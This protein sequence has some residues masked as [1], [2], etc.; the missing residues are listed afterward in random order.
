M[1]KAANNVEFVK[2]KTVMQNS[3]DSLSD[4]IKVLSNETKLSIDK[5]NG[6]LG[7]FPTQFT[8][9]INDKI[10]QLSQQNEQHMHKIIQEYATP[11]P[12]AEGQLPSD[13]VM[14]SPTKQEVFAT[15]AQD[16]EDVSLAQVTEGKIDWS[17]DLNDAT[18]DHEIFNAS[19]D[20]HIPKFCPYNDST[21]E[22]ASKWLQDFIEVLV[23]GRV[24]KSR[25]PVAIYSCLEGSALG[26]WHAFR[27]KH[28]SFPWT[29]YRQ[30]FLEA[31]KE[32]N[33]AFT[34]RCR[35]KT[36]TFKDM[37]SYFKNFCKLALL[38]PLDS[39]MDL[40]G[41]T[42]S[43]RSSPLGTVTLSTISSKKILSITLK[44]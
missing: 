22:T 18:N 28:S 26:W 1:F 39:F 43:A 12:L 38:T 36:L 8:Q 17:E 27:K 9:A 3:L 19:K 21:E 41:L 10:T 25:W 30:A 37:D 29:A 35:I 32:W 5:I 2:V 15:D 23:N 20:T 16:S 13:E 34:A 40:S 42:T 31:H 11:Q 4:N 44:K 6:K 24:S 7:A 33:P 14:P